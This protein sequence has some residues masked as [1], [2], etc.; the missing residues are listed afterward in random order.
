M[1]KKN[2]QFACSS[3]MLPEHRN[4][5]DR[6]RKEIELS[7]YRLPQLDEQEHERFQQVLDQSFKEGRPLTLSVLKENSLRR[8]TGTVIRSELWS[9]CLR[10]RTDNGV[11]TVLI[12]EIT[13]VEAA[14][15]EN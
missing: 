14:T 3:M 11:E 1:N 8:L 4:S 6:H 13:G 12:A 5:L 15:P 9:G 7:K 10:L 2:H